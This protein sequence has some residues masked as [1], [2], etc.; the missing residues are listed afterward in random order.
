MFGLF[1]Y[2]GSFVQTCNKIVDCIC[3]SLLWLTASLPVVTIGAATT[4][5]YYA[6]NTGIRYEQGHIWSAYWRSF[7]SNFK[8][9][10]IIWLLLLVIYGLVGASCYC[11]YHLCTGGMLPK[12]MFY[13]LLVVLALVMAWAN[14]LFPYL[15]KFQNTTRMILKNCFGIGLLSFPIA[16]LQVVFF[17]LVAMGVSMFPMAILCAPGIYMVLSCYTLEP[18]FRK[19]M[20]QEDRAREEALLQD[21]KS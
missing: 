14:L 18:V 10:T 21:L 5:L 6:I 13:L 1:K 20:S 2:D 17:V 4:A 15:A 11:T 12:E 8:Q 19:Y 3:L 16:L 9:A 7:R